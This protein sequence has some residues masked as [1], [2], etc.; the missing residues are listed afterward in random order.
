VNF[1]R[2]IAV[3]PFLVWGPNSWAGPVREHRRRWRRFPIWTGSKRSSIGWGPRR[4]GRTCWRRPRPTGSAKADQGRACISAGKSHC[5]LIRP[6]QLLPEKPTTSP[7][8]HLKDQLRYTTFMIPT[9]AIPP[10]VRDLLMP[11]DHQ[12]TAG[13][14]SP[15]ADEARFDCNAF[16][17]GPSRPRSHSR[18]PLCVPPKR[19]IPN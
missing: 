3:P 1:H 19:D 15:I 6:L 9:A 13:A 17:H 4:A 2:K 12:V 8:R 18:C 10:I 11:R 5:P 16:D 14:G 7:S